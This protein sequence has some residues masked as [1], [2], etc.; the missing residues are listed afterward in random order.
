MSR[1][2]KSTSN[3]ARGLCITRKLGESVVI[4]GTLK[5]H[6]GHIKGNFVQL[7]FENLTEE[8]PQIDRTEVFEAKLEGPFPLG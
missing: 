2:R 6:I 7:V 5:V 4:E 3:R 1:L 8:R